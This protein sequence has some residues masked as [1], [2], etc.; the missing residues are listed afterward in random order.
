MKKALFTLIALCCLS[1]VSAQRNH[2]TYAQPVTPVQ[3]DNYSF[4]GYYMNGRRV[5]N[6]RQSPL[7]TTSGAIDVLRID[8]SGFS[9]AVINQKGRSKTV[10][11]YDLWKANRLLH[12]FK[13]DYT[14]TALAYAP[15]SKTLAI[16]GSD[17]NIHL[18]TT[19][20]FLPFGAIE[21]PFAADE[22][23]I[24]PNNYFAAVSSGNR[25][26]IYNME[27]RKLRKELTLGAAVNAFV[28]A[29]DSNSLIVVTANGHAT[30]Y[31]TRTFLPLSDFASLGEARDCDLH[32]EN[33]YFAV[34]SGPH[35][36]TVVNKLDSNDRRNIELPEGGTTDIRF[37]KDGKGD[38]YLLYNTNNSIVYAPVVG[39]EPYYSQLLYD[40][41]NERMSTWMKQMDGESLEEYQRRVNEETRVK[42]MMLFEQEIAT[43]MAEDLLSASTVT[44]GQF[45][46]ETNMLAIDFNTMPTIYLPVPTD[47]VT[48]FAHVENLEFRNAL[49]AVTE[50]DKFELIY[51]DVYNTQTGETYTFDNR[52]RKSLEYLRS[53]DNFIPLELVQMSSMDE[54]RLK[55]I[56]ENVVDMAKRENRISDHTNIA[57]TADLIQDVDADG[58]RILNYKIGFAY[59]VDAGYSAQEDFAP[60]KYRTEQ[61][62]A[63]KAM[64]DIITEAFQTDFAPYLKAG[65]KV[66]MTI[67]GMADKLPIRNRIAYDGAYGDF[68]GE[69][70]YGEELYALTVTQADGITANDQLAF[71]RAVG[72]KTLI[73]Q[74]VPGLTGMERDYRYN[75]KV[76]DKTGGEY[77][78]ISVEITFIDAF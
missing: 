69:P 9:F 66:H 53:D 56:R 58:G 63:A 31:D 50:N 13:L 68:V 73:E 43:R 59:T 5:Y 65:K 42:Q 64:V 26:M 12:E 45:N 37:V 52:E 72:L 44:L 71:L 23:A 7:C 14:P 75:I 76:A 2:F 36:V 21:I 60:G 18:Y 25:L 15:D 54:L 46:P 33:K 61:S 6:L 40:E 16:A 10:T 47:K 34:L 30:V 39:L 19:K 17:N 48:Q 27:S 4:S 22:M 55:E 11:V 41:L 62:G 49:Y 70:V 74:Q 1:S 29:H 77:R 57:V 78:R 20:G 24:S 8:P 67:T 32:T 35:R 28:F 38:V 51:V 3:L